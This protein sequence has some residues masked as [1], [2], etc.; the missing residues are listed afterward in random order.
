MA[1][2]IL[3]Y[4][5]TSDCPMI[6]HNGQTADPLNPYA[7]A[8][9]KI[10]GK[11]LKTQADHEEMARLE[12]EAALYMSATGPFIPAA[13]I[14]SMLLAAAKKGREGPVAKAGA[15][16]AEGSSLEYTGPRDFSGLWADY[17]FRH[18]AIV[19]V[20]QARIPRHR[21]VFT[22]WAAIVKMNIEPTLVD[23]SQIDR[24]FDIAGTQIGQG[25]WRPQYGRF[26]ATRI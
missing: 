25:D 17:T 23:E 1:W 15:F 13:N 18:V 6:P 4:R 9:K 5:L 19:R 3:E 22:E 8:I 24:W 2:K 11:R 16:C 26:T 10:S 14:D 12:F 21:P 7:I 20:G